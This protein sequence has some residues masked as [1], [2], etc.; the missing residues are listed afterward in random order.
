LIKICTTL[1]WHSSIQ[2]KVLCRKLATKRV[3]DNG[4]KQSLCSEVV[5]VR[6]ISELANATSGDC[7]QLMK[8]A[9]SASCCIYLLTCG[10]TAKL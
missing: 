6:E 7:L 9:A 4:D 2:E 5:L 3:E 8:S 10:R 1:R